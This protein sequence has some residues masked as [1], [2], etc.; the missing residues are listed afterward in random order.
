MSF[1]NAGLP[2]TPF[3]LDDKRCILAESTELHDMYITLKNEC[4][5]LL[6]QDYISFM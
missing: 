3:T 2:K 5:T 6:E 1:E 4:K